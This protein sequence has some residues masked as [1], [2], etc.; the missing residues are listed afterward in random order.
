M[1][2]EKLGNI[3]IQVRGI[4]YKPNEISNFKLNDYAPI[5]K[6]NNITVDGLLSDDLIFIS[7]KKLK[8]N[9]S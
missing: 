3:V 4:S 2:F 8:Q 7:K 1:K 9:S 5:L 6:A